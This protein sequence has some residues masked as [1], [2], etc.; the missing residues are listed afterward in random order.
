MKLPNRRHDPDVSVIRSAV[1][2]HSAEKV[3]ET[4]ETER[5]PKIDGVCPNIVSDRQANL[6]A[7]H[8]PNKNVASGVTA[9]G[10]KLVQR[11]DSRSCQ[12][13]NNLLAAHWREQ[14][15]LPAIRL[16]PK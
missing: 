16:L 9:Y 6:K 11:G 2:S 4:N 7:C 10:R 15:H 13:L 5:N 8:H 12:R 14:S 1:K 3:G